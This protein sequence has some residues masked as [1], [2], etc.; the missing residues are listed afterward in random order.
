MRKSPVPLLNHKRQKK[1]RKIV[2]GIT[3]VLRENYHQ[4]NSGEARGP[5]ARLQKAANGQTSGSGLAPK[6]RFF[7]PLNHFALAGNN[8]GLPY[9]SNGHKPHSH[10]AKAEDET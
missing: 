2:R 8:L 10:H 3:G 6:A 4:P 9:E 5:A 7:Q 1:S